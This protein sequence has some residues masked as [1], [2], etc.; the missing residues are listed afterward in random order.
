MNSSDYVL[1]NYIAD[2]LFP[3]TNNSAESYHSH[4]NA[5]FYVKHPNIYWKRFNRQRIFPWTECQTG[6][7]FQIRARENSVCGVCLQRLSLI[8]MGPTPTVT[9]TRGSSC[10]SR[11]V[12]RLPRSACHEPDMHGNPRRLVRRL[13]RHACF[14]SCDSCDFFHMLLYTFVVRFHTLPKCV[15]IIN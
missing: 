8:S 1:E 14:S 11:R 9:P 5:E 2:L 10:R 15:F 13:D 4:L 12:R 6:T 3:H 7:E